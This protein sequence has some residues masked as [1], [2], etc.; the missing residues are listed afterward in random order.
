MQRS[1]VIAYS[2][3]KQ[4]HTFLKSHLRKQRSRYSFKRS[5]LFFF[6]LGMLLQKLLFCKILL[7]N[8]L[9]FM[10]SCYFLLHLYSLLKK[11]MHLL[12]FALSKKMFKGSLGRTKKQNSR[13]KLAAATG[14]RACTNSSQKEKKNLRDMLPDHWAYT[15]V[16]E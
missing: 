6:S 16:T 11:Q 3:L 4:I 13:A 10:F 14:T 8:W 9:I 2:F 5:T 12:E 7:W 15:R 1:F